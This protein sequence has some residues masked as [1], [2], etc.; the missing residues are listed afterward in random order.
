[1]DTLLTLKVVAQ[2]TLFKTLVLIQI[3]LTPRRTSQLFNQQPMNSKHL[4]F[5]T[6]EPLKTLSSNPLI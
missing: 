1:M 2:T 3:P 6:K 4:E 5:D